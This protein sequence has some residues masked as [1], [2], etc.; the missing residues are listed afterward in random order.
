[1]PYLPPRLRCGICKVWLESFG[2][3]LSVCEEC[4]KEYYEKQ[5]QNLIKYP[6]S[7]RDT[8]M[9]LV[10]SRQRDEAISNKAG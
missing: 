9:W 4:D 1:M 2:Y 5:E 3:S 10:C 6:M 7:G 8:P